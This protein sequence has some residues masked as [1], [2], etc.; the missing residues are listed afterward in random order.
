VFLA[1]FV[2]LLTL[3]AIRLGLIVD[4]FVLQ[5]VETGQ[6]ARLGARSTPFDA[7]HFADGTNAARLL[8]AGGVP[9]W[10]SPELRLAFFRP[11]ASVTHW[12]DAR[13]LGGVPAVM[14]LHSIAW[15]A[16]LTLLAAHVYRRLLGARW[17]AGLAAVCF[18]LDPGHA[19]SGAWISS[20]NAVLAA[21]F[22]LLALYAHDRARR[23]GR[24]GAWIVAA[25]AL[26]ASLASAEAGAA[27]LALL[28]A[29]AIAFEGPGLWPRVRAL[30]PAA[31][32]TLG[33]AG[34]YRGLG[35]GAAHSA[36]YVDPV[37]APAAFVR[38]AAVN[39]PINLGARLG[40]LPPALC[41]FA[42]DRAMPIFAAVAIAFIA[43]AALALARLRGDGTVRFFAIA[44][45]LAVLP[46]A[47]TLPNDRN[48]FLIGFAGFGLL[49]R[50]V[51]RAAEEPGRARRFHAGWLVMMH[52]VIAL[53]TYPANASS[54]ELFARY[55]REPLARAL[56]DAPMADA[57]LVFVNPP[58]PFFVSHLIPQ[59]AAMGVPG[60][61]HL[62]VL[63]PG[64]YAAEIRRED[65][66]R[67]V[68]RVPGGVNPR[69]GTWPAADGV[70]PL[71]KG[72]YL[73]QHLAAFARG[74][75]EAM[76][77]GSVVEMPGC[78]VEVLAASAEGGP[79]E[80]SVTFDRALE[81]ASLRWLVWKDGGFVPF[82]LPGVGETIRLVAEPVTL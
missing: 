47:G 77:A 73:A 28:A 11:L 24:R 58:S 39:L 45:V 51:E 78:R 42:A 81:D 14:H 23:E 53:L 3:P 65:A 69:P 63:Y 37:R 21:F 7:F 34:I 40:S 29:H 8:D 48:L 17:P 4:D 74:A 27:T 31:V 52:G 68:V 38:A 44:A 61:A 9:W 25:V 33:W 22:G 5:A 66:R 72:D 19:I 57:T 56:G 75:G 35:Y 60:P 50:I 32:V 70:A 13:V 49:A 10:A 16:A 67:L 76:P 36:M 20:R 1:A 18:A 41:A 54:M 59:R 82:V 2:A 26:A 12:I 15:L 46:L 79:T 80:F 62:R 30:A 6:G 55:S 64:V 71:F 43:L